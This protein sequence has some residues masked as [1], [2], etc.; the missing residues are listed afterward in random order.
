MPYQTKP[1]HTTQRKR[2]Y[3][4]MGY[5]GTVAGEILRD[6]ALSAE[7]WGEGACRPWHIWWWMMQIFEYAAGSLSGSVAVQPSVLSI[8]TLQSG[9]QYP[10]T[11][12]KDTDIQFEWTECSSVEIR[13][14]LDFKPPPNAVWTWLAKIEFHVGL[15]CCSDNQKSISIYRDMPEIGFGLAVWTRSESLKRMYVDILKLQ[16]ATS[17]NQANCSMWLQRKQLRCTLRSLFLVVFYLV[18]SRSLF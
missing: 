15:F 5:C 9:A 12:A 13:F 6:S 17:G 4:C 10:W 8:K 3:M 2:G 18:C 1:N 16:Q 11:D 7:H 14:E